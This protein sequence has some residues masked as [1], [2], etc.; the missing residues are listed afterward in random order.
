MPERKRKRVASNYAT[1]TP[2]KKTAA[3][4]PSSPLRHLPSSAMRPLLNR[5]NFTRMNKTPFGREIQPELPQ[6]AFDIF[7]LFCPD[8]MVESWVN[9]INVRRQEESWRPTFKE[10]VYLFLGVLVYMSVFPLS[11]TSSYWDTSSTTASHPITR[12]ITRERY[13]GIYHRFCTWDPTHTFSSVFEKIKAWSDHIR[14]TSLR[15]WRPSSHV[16][17]DE[18]MVRFNGRSK[19]IVHLPNK[20]ISVGYK[21]WVV[22]DSGYFLDWIF[23]SKDKGPIGYLKAQHPELAPTQGI[24]IDLLLRLPPPPSLDHGYHCF[25]DNLFTSPVLFKLLRNINIA[26]TG[27]TRPNRIDSKQLLALKAT[28]KTKDHLPWGTVFSR[29]HKEEEV[30]Q[31][32][33]KDNAFVLLLSTAFDG[34]EPPIERLRRQPSKSSTSARTA[35]EPFQGQPTKLL[36]IPQFIDQY[37][38]NMNGVD[39][40]DQLR[41]GFQSKRRIKRGGQQALLYLFLFQIIITNSFLLQK[42][43]WQSPFKTS[44]AFRQQLYIDI[45]DKFGALVAMKMNKNKNKNTEKKGHDLVKKGVRLYCAFCSSK[46]RNWLLDQDYLSSAVPQK[47]VLSV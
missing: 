13:E 31:F 15:L 7:A 38:N 29:K 28:E 32:G 9:F 30:M 20:P 34:W 43:N 39:I 8:S 47:Y 26:A 46:K 10:E 19:D 35:R 5:P 16:S 37:N 22:A 25:M 11:S 17:V 33:F 23:H 14:A 21:I 4:P 27:T 24:V 18:A 1:K 12:F 41:A 42:N 45:F 36:E 44:I 40:G 6:N 2:S 3:D